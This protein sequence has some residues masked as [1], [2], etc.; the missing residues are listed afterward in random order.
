MKPKKFLAVSSGLF[1]A[2]L[3]GAPLANAQAIVA[4]HA[5]ELVAGYGGWLEPWSNS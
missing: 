5:D 1:A 4:H 3:F 2:G